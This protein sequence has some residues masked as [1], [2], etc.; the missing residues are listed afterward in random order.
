MYVLKHSKVLGQAICD[1]NFNKKQ[2]EKYLEKKTQT[3]KNVKENAK[4]SF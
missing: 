2:G 3:D 1:E 4:D